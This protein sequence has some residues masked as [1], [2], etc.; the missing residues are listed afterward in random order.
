[1][2]RCHVES[3][4]NDELNSASTKNWLQKLASP[5]RVALLAGALAAG[6]SGLAWI[7]P[8]QAKDVSATAS[9][10]AL[11]INDQPI[12]RDGR[13]TTSFAPVVKKVASSVVKVFVTSKADPAGFEK[14]S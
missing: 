9:P 5:C 14:W 6:A 10:I 12:S 4:M 13:G 8:S 2:R 3:N 11:K 1:M 7:H